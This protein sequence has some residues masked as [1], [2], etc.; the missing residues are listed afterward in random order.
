[1]TKPGWTT[2]AFIQNALEEISGQAGPNGR[3]LCA[4]SGGVDSMVVATLVRRAVGNR[5][6]CVMV[7]HGLMRKNEPEEVAR[8][9]EDVFSSPLTIIDASDLYFE[10]LRGV[11]DPEQKRKIIGFTFIDV[12]QA[13]AKKLGTFDFLAQGTIYPDVIESGAAG[14]AVIKSHHNVGGLPESMGF[15]CIEPLRTLFKDEVRKVGTALGL[16]K[17][18]VNRQP[19]P[20]PGLGVRVV[21]EITREKVDIVR[22]ADAIYREAVQEAGLSGAISQY[23]AALLPFQTVGI[24]GGA[25]SSDYVIAL[26]AVKTE[27]FVHAAWA[28]LP[29]DLLA[30]VSRRITDE[31][32]RVGRVVVDITDKPP[33]PIEWE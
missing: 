4:L 33:A 18:L 13:E 2:E 10:R 29:F 11:T 3:V 28:P 1:M 27:N 8:A 15:V 14:D 16:P 7:N 24:H 22:H 17:T 21:G 19:F 32:P 5:L 31:I 26:R 23:F 6:T 30:A 12:F 9:F 25:P 20:C